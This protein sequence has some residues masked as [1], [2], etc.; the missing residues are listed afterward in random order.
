MAEK[1]DIDYKLEA[2][3]VSYLYPNEYASERHITVRHHDGRVLLSTWDNRAS[4]TRSPSDILWLDR[5]E[6]I[7]FFERSAQ[8]LRELP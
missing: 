2:E 8:R 4:D 7:A 6:A 3:V 1:I 5:E